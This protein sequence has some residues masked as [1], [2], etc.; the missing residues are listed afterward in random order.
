M[1]LLSSALRSRLGAV[2][3]LV[4]DQ[5]FRQKVAQRLLQE[6]PVKLEKQAGI[7]MAI[8]LL[9]H[10]CSGLMLNFKV[11]IQGYEAAELGSK[12]LGLGPEGGQEFAR[13]FSKL[14]LV[15]DKMGMPEK[16]QTKP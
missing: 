13:L 4:S 11:C 5:V 15:F 14:Q 7:A 12:A 16:A 10:G 8:E 6:M 2:G 9:Q 1:T 3:Q